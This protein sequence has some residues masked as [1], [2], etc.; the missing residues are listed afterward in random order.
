[1]IR[2]DS[3]LFWC[4]GFSYSFVL[5]IFIE[6]CLGCKRGKRV[7][8]SA[9]EIWFFSEINS[10]YTCCDGNFTDPRVWS[11]GKHGGNNIFLTCSEKPLG[12]SHKTINMEALPDLQSNIKYN[13]FLLK[14]LD[15]I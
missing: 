1:M 15:V 9:C 7:D 3:G 10:E 5:Y 12:G 13:L 4:G 14:F 11:S 6:Y 2:I 8:S